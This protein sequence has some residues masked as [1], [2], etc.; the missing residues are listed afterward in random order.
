MID[1]KGALEKKNKLSL[2]K[3]TFDTINFSWKGCGHGFVHIEA[4]TMPIK[5]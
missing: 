5:N 1:I 3:V 2:D 4:Q